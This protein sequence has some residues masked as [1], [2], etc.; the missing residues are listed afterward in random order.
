[1][2]HIEGGPTTNGDLRAGRSCRQPSS[3][4]EERG[5]TD[6][7]LRAGPARRA[8]GIS[9]PAA[10]PALRRPRSARLSRSPR[11]GLPRSRR[12]A[13]RQAHPTALGPARAA[14]ER[15]DRLRAVSRSSGPASSGSC[16]TEA[17]AIETTTTASPPLQP[18]P[19]TCGADRRA[20]PSRK[21]DAEAASRPRDLGARPRPRVSCTS[22][23]SST[24]R[25]P[26][27]GSPERITAA[28]HALLTAT[29]SE[30]A[31]R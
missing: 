23:A 29:K 16:F 11:V 25:N 18:Y 7:S 3:L 24:R 27:G 21:A 10:L 22:T 31:R 20:K 1:M 13:G 4:L 9:P 19:N 15:G 28:I 30:G 14:R 17:P 2:V 12:A 6:L 8:G 5:E 26:T